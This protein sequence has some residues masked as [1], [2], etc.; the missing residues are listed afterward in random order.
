MSTPAGT[1]FQ[2]QKQVY[3]KY[4]GN[5]QGF[6][7]LLWFIIFIGV[8]MYL[9]VCGTQCSGSD[10][11]GLTASSIASCN[12]DNDNDELNGTAIGCMITFSLLFITIAGGFLVIHIN[13]ANNAKSLISAG[14]AFGAAVIGYTKK[15]EEPELITYETTQFMNKTIAMNVDPDTLTENR[16]RIVA[17]EELNDTISDLKQQLA[18]AS[19]T[20]VGAT[21]VGDTNVGDTEYESDSDSGS[22]SESDEE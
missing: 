19:A 10:A 4:V 21:N 18:I 11:C 12:D 2:D 15:Q 14:D 6:V 7:A 9:Q 16:Y 8:V 5:Y 22:D 20:N 17:E 13:T 3:D 1:N